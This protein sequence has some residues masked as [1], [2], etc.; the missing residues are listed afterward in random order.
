LD[1]SRHELVACLDQ[2]PANRFEQAWSR[3]VN[4]RLSC[5]R[6]ELLNDVGDLS[7]MIGRAPSD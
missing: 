1:E 7:R 4:V 6:P 5:G 2:G 3:E